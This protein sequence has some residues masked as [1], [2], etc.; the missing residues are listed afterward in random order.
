MVVQAL[1]PA[2]ISPAEYLCREREAKTKHEYLSGTVCEMAG[3]SRNH[4]EIQ[5]AL[6]TE[7]GIAL[8]GKPCRILPADTKLRVRNAYYYPDAMIAC[9]P[10]Y[11]DDANGVIDNPTVVVE[12]LSP[13]TRTL[14][15]GTKFADYRT[16]PSLGDY[17]LI[18]SEARG[19]EV[20]SLREGEW[21]VRAVEAGVAP[22]PSLGIALD[23]DELYRH[24]A[25]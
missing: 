3:A 14:D 18:D 16:L 2:L 21:M 11:V 13:S 4:I 19:V 15:R 23:L 7:V 9:P 6:A 20:F 1:V 5:A 17:V 12:V 24:I 25:L 8:R 10:R 22:L